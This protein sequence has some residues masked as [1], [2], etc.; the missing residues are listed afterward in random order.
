V[1]RSSGVAVQGVLDGMVELRPAGEASPAAG[2]RVPAAR[3]PVLDRRDPGRG[4]GPLSG[5]RHDSMASL[6][7]VFE[8]IRTTRAMRRLDPTRDVS[9][10]DLL[11]IVEAATKGPSGSNAQI[12]RWL[13]VRDAEKRK[14]LGEIYAAAWA[15]VREAYAGNPMPDEDMARVL[16]SASYLGDHM[17]DAP[18]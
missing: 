6:M 12:T 1:G 5:T 9:D 10:A 16:R 7:D 18:A 13:V 2:P 11:T 4:P 14:R 15:P 3:R 8:A 17:G